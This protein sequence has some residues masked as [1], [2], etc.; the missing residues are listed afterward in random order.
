MFS[1]VYENYV[2]GLSHLVRDND[3]AMSS[4]KSTLAAICNA[5]V[6]SSEATARQNV[7]FSSDGKV[8]V[9]EDDKSVI[10]HE[11]AVDVENSDDD[12]DVGMVWVSRSQS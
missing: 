8:D 7:L 12:S 2:E 9:G 1:K 3:E 10:D 5:V 11:T 4:F 6:D